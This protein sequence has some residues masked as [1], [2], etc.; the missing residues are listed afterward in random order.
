TRRTDRAPSLSVGSSTPRCQGDTGIAAPPARKTH[1]KNGA[2]AGLSGRGS[3]AV[4]GRPTPP[5]RRGRPGASPRAASPRLTTSRGRL[6]REL[7][8]EAVVRAAAFVRPLTDLA[9]RVAAQHRTAVLLS[10]SRGVVV[11]VVRLTREPER[12][13]ATVV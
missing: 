12:V 10:R 7:A 2:L 9:R 8:D 13:A 11:P 4:R 3:V 1:T 6:E 5:Y